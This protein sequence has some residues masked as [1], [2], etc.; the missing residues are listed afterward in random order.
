M[1]FASQLVEPHGLLME[2]AAFDRYRDPV[3]DELQQFDIVLA[4]P[5]MDERADMDYAQGVAFCEQRHAEQRLDSLLPQ[6]RVEH[7][8]V[9]DVVE[10]H[11]LL[12][13]GDATGEAPADRDADAL[14][15][16]FLDPDGCT[17]DQLVRIAVE[18]EDRAGVGRECVADAHQQ[19]AEELLE[20]EVRERDVCDRLQAVELRGRFARL[21]HAVPAGKFLG[22]RALHACIRCRHVNRIS[23]YRA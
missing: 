20:L 13:G 18:H 3:G 9:I 22:Y 1:K 14:L 2:T 6:D 11:R 23:I 10:D 17:C 8:R 5:A 16:L 12:L 7:V 4:E 21:R 19:L 15:Y